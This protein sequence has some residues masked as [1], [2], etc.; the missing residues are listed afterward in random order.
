MMQKKRF[1]VDNLDYYATQKNFKYFEMDANGDNKND[2]CSYDKKKRKLYCALNTTIDKYAKEDKEEVLKRFNRTFRFIDLNNDKL[3][4]ICYR[5][6]ESYVCRINNG[7]GFNREKKWLAL[8]KTTW[9]FY[10][11]KFKKEKVLTP[12]HPVYKYLTIADYFK[13]KKLTAY[14][15]KTKPDYDT[16]WLVNL[17]EGSIAMRDIDGDGLADFTAII[18]EELYWAKNLGNGF[19]KLEKLERLEPDVDIITS[20]KTIYANWLKHLFGLSTEIET[21]FVNTAY[22]PVKM[23]SDL[24]GKNNKELCYRSIYGLS[25]LAITNKPFSLLNSVTNSLGKTSTIEYGKIISDNL[26]NSANSDYEKSY[27]TNN[28]VVKSVTTDDGVGGTNSMLYKYGKMVFSSDNKPLGFDSLTQINTALKAKSITYYYR[29]DSALNGQ[30]KKVESY[31]DGHLTSTQENYYEEVKQQEPYLNYA[32]LVKKVK[33]GYDINGQELFKKVT[34]SSDFNEYNAPKILK[35]TTTDVTGLEYTVTTNTEYLNDTTNWLINKPT[36]VTVTHTNGSSTFTRRMQS[37]Y[38]DNGRLKSTTI[39]PGSNDEL[40]TEYKY[41]DDVIVTTVT[42][43]AGT[44][45]SKKYLDDLDRVIKTEN[46]LKQIT[47]QIKYDD[48]CI[49]Q[50]KSVTDISGLTTTFKYD[51]QCRLIEKSMPNGVVVTTSYQLSDHKADRGV[52]F[53]EVGFKDIDVTVYMT[54]TS[55][56]IGGWS[57]TYYDALERPVRVVKKGYKNKNVIVDTVYDNAGRVIG[58]TL[59]Y[60]E[61]HGKGYNASWIK[62]YYDNFG[63]LIKQETPMHKGKTQV[64]TYSY[65]GLSTTITSPNNHKKIVY[66]NALDKTIK[67]TQND[68]TSVYYYYD[69]LGN[70]TQTKVGNRVT[71]ITYDKLGRKVA[72]NTPSLAPIVLNGSVYISIICVYMHSH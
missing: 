33:K 10:I 29:E 26:K 55:D 65:D 61:G 36:A 62:S 50:P 69:A 2:L 8:D 39:E 7:K 51:S 49:H 15:V 41:S 40:K 17:Q 19:G 6:G 9:P 27:Y 45:V 60:F 11:A 59:P 66:K 58:K 53:N 67:I 57:R 25:C 72:L 52:D 12:W 47:S 54:T 28:F 46:A 38:Y 20:R 24:D 21:N 5:R 14:V 34:E 30:V 43:K 4:D 48:F 64:T 63:R 70:L 22:G 42:F 44:R 31:M 35:E 16:K 71:T 23:V 37:S 32:R 56:N 3:P 68:G 18:A 1:D 13:N